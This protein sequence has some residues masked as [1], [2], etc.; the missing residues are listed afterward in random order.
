MPTASDL[1]LWLLGEGQGWLLVLARVSGLAWTAPAWG[2]PAMAWRVRVGFSM[3]LTTVLVP[4]VGPVVPAGSPGWGWTLAGLGLTEAAIGLG[5]GLSAGLVVAGARQAGE[6][7]GAQAGLSPASLIDPE[8]GGELTPLGH[9]YGLIALAIFLALDGPLHLVDALA[10]SYRA[11]PPGRLRLSPELA[12]EA[13]GRVG[14]ALSLAVRAAAPAAL[15]LALAGVVLTLLARTAGT[16]QFA[17]LAWPIRA[18]VGL[19]LVLIG[20]TGLAGTL[21]VAWSDWA[22]HVLDRLPN[23]PVGP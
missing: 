8:A 17:S 3:L 12:V 16:L 1:A 4:L 18:I 20:L 13:F 15:A 21:N 22:I 2:T 14:W 5:L 11:L 9:L 19:L 7:V 10:E 6:I 23:L